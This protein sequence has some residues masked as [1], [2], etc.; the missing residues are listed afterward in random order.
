MFWDRNTSDKNTEAVRLLARAYYRANRNR[1]RIL[2]GAAVCGIVVLCTVFSI[3]F[4]KIEAEYL[5]AAREHGT[6][7]VTRLERGTA[8]QYQKL[9]ELDYIREVGKEIK[10]GEAYAGEEAS[11]EIKALDET[12]WEKLTVPAYTGICGAYPKKENEIMLSRRALSALGIPRP[13]VGMQITLTVEYRLFHKKTAAFTL[14][15]YF[16]DYLN[17]DTSEPPGYVSQRFAEELGADWD[18]PDYLQILQKDGTSGEDIERRL[19]AEIETTDE[20]QRFIGGNTFAYDAMEKFT[21]GWK[22]AMICGGLILVSVFLLVQN[23]MQISMQKE[24]RQYGLLQTIGATRRQQGKIFLRQMFRIILVAG[25]LGALVSVLLIQTVL[26]KILGNLYLNLFGRAEELR[27]LRPEIPAVSIAFVSAA[28]CIAAGR[29]LHRLFRL[30]PLEALHDVGEAGRRPKERHRGK[31]KRRKQFGAAREILFMAWK[32]L[33]RYP[34]RFALTVL[35]LF[36][37][38]TAALVTVVIGTG[39]DR[40]HEIQREPDFAI[41]SSISA[42]EMSETSADWTV[43]GHNQFSPISKELMK[44]IENI[45]G[46]DKDTIKLTKGAYFRVRDFGDTLYPLGSAENLNQK[47]YDEYKDEGIWGTAVTV[48]IVEEAYLDRLQELAEKHSLKIDMAMLRSGEGFLLIHAHRLSPEAQRMGDETVGKPLSFRPLR[49]KEWVRNRQKQIDSMTAGELYD[50]DEAHQEE[51]EEEEERAWESAATLKVAGYVDTHP[52][53]FPPLALEECYDEEDLPIYL[54]VSRKGFEKL[55]EE[56]KLFHVQFET[57]QGKE[58]LVK[59]ALLKLIQEENGSFMLSG[60]EKG[61]Y[62]TAKSDLMSE[63]QSSIWTNRILM[64]T[65]SATLIFM[66]IMN[67]F[68]IMATSIAAREKEFGAL[69]SIGMT[70][71]QLWLLL[72]AEGMGYALI[73]AGLT[74]TLGTAALKLAA[75]YIKARVSYFVFAFPYRM[76]GGMIS[77]LILICVLLPVRLYKK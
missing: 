8:A 76:A 52:K 50:W 69:R 16:T 41:A 35:S 46:V 54:L 48:Q 51:W 77:A 34:R 14:S 18:Y 72:L 49:S 39:L 25:A 15:G 75:A 53:D 65:L 31:E 12:A 26:T 47:I 60:D 20:G 71:R 44:K 67:Y 55:G 30:T 19:Y 29:T 62:M 10:V 17:P 32:N 74:A 73:T 43:R 56:E 38:M 64:G 23:V 61:V 4:G 1:N 37:G 70:A 7:A 5:R 58:P 57:E 9:K 45:N 28:I 36:L 11:L 22:I 59:Q 40:T 2:T 42:N 3:V 27:I 6:V 13:E 66:G 24:I 68:N 21:G 63:A 33:F